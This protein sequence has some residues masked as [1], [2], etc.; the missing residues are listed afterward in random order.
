MSD[1]DLAEFKSSLPK[2]INQPGA[3][4]EIIR[5]MREINQYL[6][7]EGE[8]ADMVL[9]GLITPAEGRKRLAALG[10]PVQDFFNRTQQPTAPRGPVRTTPQDN[11]LILKYLRPGQ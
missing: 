3:N 11:S 2:I 9:D 8:I 1:A 7:K 6:I 10:N 5:G 4:R